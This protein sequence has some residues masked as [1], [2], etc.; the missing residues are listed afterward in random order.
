MVGGGPL[1]KF[2][3]PS[4]SGPLPDLTPLQFPAPAWLLQNPKG[5]RTAEKVLRGNVVREFLQKVNSEKRSHT[6]LLSALTARFLPHRGLLQKP[7]R[8]PGASDLPGW[9]LISDSKLSH[10][11]ELSVLQGLDSKLK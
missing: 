7:P 4:P 9:T 11:L 3:L 5:V 10:C 2:F 6:R 1:R 8:A